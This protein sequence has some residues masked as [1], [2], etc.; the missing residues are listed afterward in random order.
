MILVLTMMDLAFVMTYVMNPAEAT[1]V[2][3]DVLILGAGMTGMAAA[4]RLKQL[5][6]DSYLIIEGSGKVGGRA[7]QQS[8][9]EYQVQMGPLWVHGG[10]LNLLWDL[11][12]ARNISIL[13]TDYDDWIVYNDEGMNITGVANVIY[14]EGFSEALEK[15]VEFQHNITLSGAPDISAKAALRLVGWNAKTPVEQILELWEIDFESGTLPDLSSAKYLE[16]YRYDEDWVIVDQQEGFLGIIDDIRNEAA[17]PNDS[18]QKLILNTVIARV[19]Q[20][21]THVVVHAEDGRSFVGKQAIVTFSLGVLQHKLVAFEPDLPDWKWNSIFGYRMGDY[22]HFYLQFASTFWD[23]EEWIVYADKMRGYYPL[24]QNFNKHWP[25]SNILQC[26]ITEPESTRL[27]YLSDSEIQAEAMSVLRTIYGNGIPEPIDIAVPRWSTDPLFMGSY[28]DWTAGFSNAS[29]AALGASVG[30]VNFAGEHT[31][32]K[33]YG[34]LIGSYD[35]GIKSAEQVAKCI[36]DD[37]E[38][39]VYK[40]AYENKGCT[41]KEALNFDGNAI[42]DDGWCTFDDCLISDARVLCTGFYLQIIIIV[43]QTAIFSS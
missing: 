36:Q 18:T 23:D 41:Y 5:G 32:Y 10:E 16:L 37:S 28:S 13:Q 19:E 31:S 24:W 4:Q 14:D 2:D 26:V 7:R 9:G 3:A 21:D 6:V 39:E 8:L 42:Q 20:N 27:A 30:R 1:E 35:E 34:F 40:A 15:I 11:V 33:Y 25:G 12:H 17:S 22:M 29:Q 43:A 38:C